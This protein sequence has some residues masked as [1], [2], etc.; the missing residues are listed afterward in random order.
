LE[1][2]ADVGNFPEP[3]GMENLSWLSKIR[4]SQEARH[5]TVRKNCRRRQPPGWLADPNETQTVWVSRTVRNF[6]DRLHRDSHEF[7]F[8]NLLKLKNQ[9]SKKS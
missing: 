8:H 7:N 9:P 4:A 1:I 6:E 5:R 2:F 3:F